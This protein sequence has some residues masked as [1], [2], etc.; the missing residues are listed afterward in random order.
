MTS[1]ELQIPMDCEGISIIYLIKPITDSSNIEIYSIPII[2]HTSDY[3]KT[4]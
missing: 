4:Y 1:Y 2:N 3:P